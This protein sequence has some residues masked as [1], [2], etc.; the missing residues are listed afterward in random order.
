MASLNGEQSPTIQFGMRVSKRLHRRIKVWCVEH[1][2]S[3]S[4]FVT[5]AVQENLRR[6]RTLSGRAVAGKAALRAEREL[7]HRA[8]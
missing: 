1:D 5:D 6:S 8:A 3:I 4:E 2:V 7:S